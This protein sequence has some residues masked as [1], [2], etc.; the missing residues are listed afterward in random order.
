MIQLNNVSIYLISNGRTLVDGISFTLNPGDRTVIIGEEGNGKS[1]LLKLIAD[2]ALIADHAEYSGS[3]NVGRHRIGYLPQELTEPERAMPVKEYL[4][5]DEEKLWLAES[6]AAETGLDPA[7]LYEDRPMKT[8]SGGE[9]VKLRLVK[10]LTD[11][12]DMLLLDEPTND[13]DLDTLVWLEG[14]ICRFDGGVLFVSHDETLI[15]NTA[16]AVIHLEHVHHKKV[17]R[18]TV[19]NVPYR[20]YMADRER[21][22]SHQ[23]QVSKFE[24]DEF[25][26][27]EARWREIY[28]K[29][30]TAQRN[31]SRRDPSTGRL[32]KKKMH[33]VMSQGRKLEKEKEALTEAPVSEWQI[34][35]ALPEVSM[36]GRKEILRF[37]CEG[38]FSPDGERLTA[39]FRLNVNAAEHVAIIGRNG[40]GKTTLLR[41]IES[42]LKKRR[43][44][45][46]FYMPQNYFELLDGYGTPVELLAPTG[47]K[48]AVTRARTY[49]GSVRFT[50]DEAESPIE[51]LSGG[52][53]A[54]LLFVKMALDG[55][56]VLLLDEPTRN[57]SP[58]SNPVI[59]GMLRDFGGCVIAVTHDRRFISEVCERAVKLTENGLEEAS[60]LF[61]AG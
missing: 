25:R 42:E 36:P 28:E 33:S 47:E 57:F 10:L 43:D 49:L 22:L 41:L 24:H 31:L 45:K 40:V 11:E 3:V 48:D 6:L 50:K 26:K 15:E 4:A 58:L 16:T 54:K 9:R 34:D 38:L 35:L 18:H 21:A 52:Q 46:V 60:P 61:P 53:K 29:V 37:S 14:F 30:D 5:A 1:T 59:R 19:A 27:K 23:A 7:I 51:R 56:N 44:L 55:Y 17:A 32:L 20:E 13:I 8:L 2:P 12:P 39:G